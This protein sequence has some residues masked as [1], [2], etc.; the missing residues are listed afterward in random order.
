MSERAMSGRLLCVI[1]IPKGGTSTSSIMRLA[2]SSWIACCSR[3]CTIRRTTAFS[4]TPGHLTTIR[5]TRWSARLGADV[6]GCQIEVKPIA[7]LRMRDEKGIDDK[8]RCVR[9]PIQA[10]TRSRFSRTFPRGSAT[11][12]PISS[13][14]I[15]TWSE[16]RSRWMAGTR[17]RMHSRRS[18]LR[19]LASRSG[20]GP[21]LGRISRASD[22]PRRLQCNGNAA[23]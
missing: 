8:V 11:R 17:A 21:R 3:Q 1:E 2:R 20:K 22:G 7:L 4:P 13:R 5:W 14:S 19:G 15:R 18:R 9:A 12:L 10:G 23:G 6:S 16:S